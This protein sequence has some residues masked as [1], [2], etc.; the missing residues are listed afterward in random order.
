MKKLAGIGISLGSLMV[1]E[2]YECN[3]IEVYVEAMGM[4]YCQ[5]LK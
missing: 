1:V 4:M 5:D 2:I 3:D